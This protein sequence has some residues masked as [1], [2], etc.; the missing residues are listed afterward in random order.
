MTK[1]LYSSHD[2]KLWTKEALVASFGKSG[3]FYYEIV[4]G[5]DDRPV[6]PN[7]IRKSLG[8]ENTFDYDL[9]EL[10]DMK[11]ALE[12]IARTVLHRLEKSKKFGKTLTLKVKFKDFS[13]ITRSQSFTTEI[14]TLDQLVEISFGLLEQIDWTQF[15]SGVRLLGITCSNFGDKNMSLV[16]K[17]HQLTL[18]F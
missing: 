3:G 5:N 11:L 17:G 8:A 14:R 7:R 10:V 12:P 13:Q 9:T 1:L 16:K 2:L 15:P 18:N 6:N 4:R